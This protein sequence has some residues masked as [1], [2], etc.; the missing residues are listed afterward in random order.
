M[1]SQ[2][3]V[4]VPVPANTELGIEGP[5]QLQPYTLILEYSS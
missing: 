5:A 2:S 3:R 1:K 4:M